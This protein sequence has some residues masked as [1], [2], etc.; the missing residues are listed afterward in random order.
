M[1]ER[2]YQRSH[3]W[4]TFA[5]DL[6]RLP[7]SFWF[8]LGECASKCDHLQR[9]AM[10]HQL[11]NK[12]HFVSLAK[13]TQATVAIEGNT[14]TLE[15]VQQL[16]KAKKPP[17]GDYRR[18]EVTNVIGL[19]DKFTIL[20]R[21]NRAPVLSLALLSEINAGILR[22]LDVAA[23]PGRLRQRS[24]IVPTYRGAYRGAPEQ[25]CPHLLEKMCGWLRGDD[26]EFRRVR[27]ECGRKAAGILR[28]AL[29]HLYIAWIHPYD[30]GNGRTARMAE[31]LILIGAG[32]PEPAAHLISNHC[33]HLRDAYYRELAEA[34]AQRDSSG[35]VRFIVRGLRDGLRKQLEYVY[36]EHILL[37]WQ[38][39]LKTA[40]T[41]YAEA[42]ARRTDLAMFL[43]R[44]TQGGKVTQPHEIIGADV[45]MARRYPVKA[46]TPALLN[47]LTALTQI[48][49]LL[50]KE[51]DGYRAKLELL[52]GFMPSDAGGKDGND[53]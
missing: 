23:V 2:R 32:V 38:E 1:T 33:N 9:T 43:A 12:L 4:L 42:K 34:S 26:G 35:F 52:R 14:L 25:D 49:G 39:Y 37:I 46:P 8:D 11:Q 28:A 50:I 17:E 27:E 5:L 22:G 10:S 41:G 45:I 6:Q 53:G 7:P 3:P 47:D 18:T 30:D 51:K 31:F 19:L 20:A 16:T 24:V 48:N 15:E 40:V 21:E 29:A 44:Q 36:G 13:G